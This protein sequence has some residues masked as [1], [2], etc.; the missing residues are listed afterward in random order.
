MEWNGMEWNGNGTG[1]GTGTK[2]A[3]AGWACPA[4]AKSVTENGRPYF[5][6]G[7]LFRN[8]SFRCK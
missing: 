7:H 3:M 2:P 5:Q 8:G 1:T 4:G 6:K